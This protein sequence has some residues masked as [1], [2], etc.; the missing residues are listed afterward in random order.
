MGKVYSKAVRAI[1]AGHPATDQADIIYGIAV[2]CDRLTERL[3]EDARL[4]AKRFA[5]YADRVAAGEMPPT[6][7]RYTTASDIESGE[8]A[9]RQSLQAIR[10]LLIACYGTSKVNEWVA[11]VA[12]A[13][14]EGQ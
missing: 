12:A 5:V 1:F 9:L 7:T 10:L 3:A 14:T 2:E 11:A 4:V 8:A 6:P 13:R